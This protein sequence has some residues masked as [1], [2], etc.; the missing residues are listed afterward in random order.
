[1]SVHLPTFSIICSNFNTLEADYCI[2]VVIIVFCVAQTIFNCLIRIRSLESSALLNLTELD[3][4]SC[5]TELWRERI[6]ETQ[7]ALL[8]LTAVLRATQYWYCVALSTAAH[9][10]S[11]S[12][13]Y[14]VRLSQ[15]SMAS[16]VITPTKCSHTHCGAFRKKWRLTDRHWYVSL[17]RDPDDVPHCRILSSNKTEWRFISATLCGW[18]RCFVAD[19]LWFTT[20]IRQKRTLRNVTLLITSHHKMI[21][22]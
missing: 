15:R 2:Q 8:V 13:T 19:Q 9:P 7:D 18:R 14:T 16:A 6:Y 20:C 3:Y 17:W 4:T 21:G 22:S 12:H 10:L 5:N 1:M 11:H